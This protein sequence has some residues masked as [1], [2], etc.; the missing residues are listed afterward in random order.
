MSKWACCWAKD[1]YLDKLEKKKKK[2]LRL[3]MCRFVCFMLTGERLTKYRTVKC[4]LI[5]YWHEL[6]EATLLTDSGCWK[7]L[8]L[9]ESRLSQERRACGTQRKTKLHGKHSSR[10]SIHLT[11]VNDLTIGLTGQEHTC[12]EVKEAVILE[13]YRPRKTNLKSVHKKYF[14][15]SLT[16]S[17]FWVQEPSPPWQAMKSTCFVPRQGAPAKPPPLGARNAPLL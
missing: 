16:L 2:F 7:L 10:K 1:I 14:Y 15:L 13:K 8:S 17:S 4:C 5:M 12:K 6:G 9:L 11:A 3:S